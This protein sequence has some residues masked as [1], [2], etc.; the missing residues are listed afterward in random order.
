MVW[1][2]AWCHQGFSAT[3][4]T[5]PEWY[6]KGS[7]CCFSLRGPNVYSCGVSSLGVLVTLGNYGQS[8]S[9]SCPGLPIRQDLL[10]NSPRCPCCKLCLFR[11]TIGTTATALQTLRIMPPFSLIGIYC[12][13][14][15]CFFCGFVCFFSVPGVQK[16]PAANRS[17]LRVQNIGMEF[18]AVS[19]TPRELKW[20]AQHFVP[21]FFPEL[22]LVLN[23]LSTRF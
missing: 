15:D 5:K 23:R 17:G 16:S 11:P 19:S 8:A 10:R 1:R 13:P 20:D 21:C 2:S 14:F 4:M 3:Q 9:R 22:R 12:S 6:T 18:R 7:S